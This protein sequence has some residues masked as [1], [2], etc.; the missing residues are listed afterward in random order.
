MY[1][2]YYIPRYFTNLFSYIGLPEI[3][4]AV[5]LYFVLQVTKSASA[6]SGFTLRDFSLHHASIFERA[7]W[8]VSKQ[9][10]ICEPSMVMTMSSA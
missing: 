9:V 4:K 6:F 5:I 2:K 7:N 1:K 10:W 8:A 3:D